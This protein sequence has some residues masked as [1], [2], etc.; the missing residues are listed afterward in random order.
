MLA[1]PGAME[2]V[3]FA[4]LVIVAGALFCFFGYLAFRV[5]IPLWGALVGFGVGA[6]AVAAWTDEGFLATGLS[7][8]V[9]I[10]VALVFALVAYLFYE[11]AVVIAM[12]SIGFALGTSLMAALDVD[13]TWVVVL[14]G[15]GLG[16]LLALTAIVAD[17]PMVLLV[18]LSALAGASAITT[19][20]MVLAGTIGT[21]EFT[22]EAVTAR[23]SDDWWWY[24]IY[25]AIAF[26]GIVT[27]IR[28]AAGV[29][30]SMRE[31]WAGR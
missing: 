17:L 5:I 3:V 9:G 22:D 27:Q 31:S 13:W 24:A 20:I 23:A 2:D 8:A 26:F 1:A 25:L 6:G 4:L 12:G 14:V 29:R 30:G 11:V 10:G 18:V 15:V 19:G 7:W 28:L 16:I 21:D